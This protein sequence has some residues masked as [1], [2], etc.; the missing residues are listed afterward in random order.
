MCVEEEKGRE[1]EGGRRKERENALVLGSSEWR[2]AN[3]FSKSLLFSNIPNMSQE[4]CFSLVKLQ[5]LGSE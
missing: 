1:K 4:T 5:S 2:L 3:W